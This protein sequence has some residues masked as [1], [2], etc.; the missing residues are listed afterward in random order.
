MLDLTA[1]E[2]FAERIGCA[3]LAARVK[4]ANGCTYCV[5]RAEGWNRVA[6]DQP[7]RTFP[8]CLATP[9]IQFEPD[10]TKLTGEPSC[11][12][13]STSNTD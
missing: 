7:H 3:V 4:A 9:G 10:F 11:A 1:P 6:C 13:N 5:H 12:D 8:R 2:T